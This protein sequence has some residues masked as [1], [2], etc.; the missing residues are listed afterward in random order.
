PVVQERRRA[1][2]EVVT[3]R[4]LNRRQYLQQDEDDADHDQRA[5][6]TIAALYG[7]HQQA[8]GDGEERRQDSVQE[9]DRPP[10]ERERA[11][12]LRQR[13]EE[14]PLLPL[15]QTLKHSHG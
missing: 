12:G 6:E 2:T 1:I 4:R 8:H 13:R 9:D 3:D 11:V 7:S 10:R 5:C 14:F 15:T